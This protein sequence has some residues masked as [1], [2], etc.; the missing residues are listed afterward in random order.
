MTGEMVQN[1]CYI[2]GKATMKR[3]RIRRNIK[4]KDGPLLSAEH[5]DRKTLWENWLQTMNTHGDNLCMGERHLE[6]GKFTGYKYK[7]YR[8]VNVD[9]Q[10]FRAGM[11]HLGVEPN[12]HV[13]IYCKNRSEWQVTDIAMQ[14]ISVASIPLYDTLGP[15]AAEYV[16]ENAECVACVVDMSGLATVCKIQ[17]SFLKL[18]VALPPRTF[19]PAEKHN[20][21]KALLQAAATNNM[22]VVSYDEVLKIGS[23]NPCPA[24]PPSGSDLATICYTSG[25]TG[26]PKGVALTHN[27]MMSDVIAIKADVPLYSSDCTISYLPLAHMYQRCMEIGIFSGGGKVGYYRGDTLLLLDDIAACQPTLFFGVP[28]LFNRIYDKI[29]TQINEA[30]C[31]KRNMFHW[32]YNWKK[33]NLESDGSLT[34]NVDFVFAKIR[35]A[36]GGKVRLMVTG[37]A[38]ISPVIMEFLRICCSSVVLEGYGQTETA[39]AVTITLE[40]DQVGAGFV[41]VPMLCSEVALFNVP[42]MNYTSVDVI[43]G[44]FVERGEICFRGP[45]MTAGYWKMP[46]KTA[47]MIDEDGWLHSGDIGMWLEN[48]YLKIIDRKKNIFKLSQ[49]EYVAPEKVENVYA[50]S[51]FIAQSFVYGDSL[52]SSLVAVIVPDEEVVIP[53]LK[54]NGVVVSSLTEACKQS[55]LKKA[56]EDDMKRIA[57]E[58]GLHGFE[59]AKAIH[60]HDDL[61]SLEN[62]LLTPTFK[63]KRPIVKKQFEDVIAHLYTTVPVSKSKL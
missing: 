58:R 26:V 13:A 17:N 20:E 60:L 21:Y 5:S 31:L 37:S 33:K 51:P 44:K 12:Q 41:G 16:L 39:A 38:P 25:T 45:N 43:D 53:W 52:K 62:G 29:M 42:E 56:V 24:V 7:T 46:E 23:R 10:R 14:S 59:Q 19:E 57:K 36:F 22:K 30:N 11:K 40:E 8:E 9:V 6:N 49:G 47:E 2:H 34:S 48:G 54:K 15:E 61:F 18:V 3:G 32:A 1:K 4:I 55:L 50:V 28:R 35:N 63:L 27:N